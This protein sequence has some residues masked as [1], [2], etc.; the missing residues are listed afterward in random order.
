MRVTLGFSKRLHRGYR[1]QF[2]CFVVIRM[3]G[4]WGL[5]V[6][7]PGS[8]VGLHKRTQFVFCLTRTVVIPLCSLIASPS[9]GSYGFGIV[10]FLIIARDHIFRSAARQDII[11]WRGLVCNRIKP[12]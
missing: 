11:L 7:S 3:P 8:C 1:H 12:Q 2:K 5:H 9:C 6:R 10:I 4:T